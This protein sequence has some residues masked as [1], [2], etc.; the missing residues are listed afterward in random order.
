[1]KALKDYVALLEKEAEANDQVKEAQKDLEAK[2]A[3][4]YGKLTEDEIKT[5]V[6]DDKWLATLAAA[7]QSELDRVSQL[8]TGSHPSGLAERYAAPLPQLTTEVETLAA[9]V[10]EPSRRW[11]VLV[12]EEWQTVP[13]GRVATLQ[14]GYD[15][16]NRLRRQGTVPIITSAGVGGSHAESRVAGP[17]VITGRYGTIG[18]VFFIEKD[19]W[20]LNTTLFVKDFHGNDPL[21]V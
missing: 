2:V 18:E 6:V 11:G 17:G 5:M 4:K 15:L 7:V 21:F 12:S 8:L 9:R 14:R 20:P 1:M 10:A 3:A 19:F 13:L 16:P